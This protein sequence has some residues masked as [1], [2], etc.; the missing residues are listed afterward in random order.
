MRQQ[1]YLVAIYLNWLIY[2]AGLA[3]FLSARNF[4]AAA[5]WI[6]ALPLA[7]WGY[8][9][10]FPRISP[11]MGYGSVEDV[12]AA[13]ST[14]AAAGSPEVRIYTALSC[15]FCP[16]VKRRLEALRARMGFSLVEVDVTLKP[17]LLLEK[18]I[19]AVPVVEAG[20]D[21]LVG[22]ATSEQLAR[23][24]AGAARRLAAHESTDGS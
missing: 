15:P 9:K 23:L 10:I 1:C 6:I 14:G 11:A 17:G 12:P 2:I 22:N 19:R 21:R 13:A 3:Y 16:L 5:A 7:L 24:I 18:Q 4:I 8:I 20:R